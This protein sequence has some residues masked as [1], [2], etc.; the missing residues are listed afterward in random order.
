MR[1]LSKLLLTLVFALSIF[2]FYKVFIMNEVSEIS[3]QEFKLSKEA[4]DRIKFLLN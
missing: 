1:K 2:K 4:I 3:K